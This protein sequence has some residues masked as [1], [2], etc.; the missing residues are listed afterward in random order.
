MKYER[1][2]SRKGWCIKRCL[3]KVPERNPGDIYSSEKEHERW[4]GRK[5]RG[6]NP[7]RGKG[8]QRWR[9]ALAKRCNASARAP[10][11]HAASACA[12]TAPG[13]TWPELL[14]GTAALVRQHLHKR[15]E[16]TS[17]S[18]CKSVLLM[19]NRCSIR[20]NKRGMGRV[21]GAHKHGCARADEPDRQQLGIQ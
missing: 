18:S 7:H 20:A 15:P 21:T 6:H 16:T 11:G 12:T 14:S 2:P 19:W 3:W 4:L 17:G 13:L 1:E 10:T 9:S 8:G 5:V